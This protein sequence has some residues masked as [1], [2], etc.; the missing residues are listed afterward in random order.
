MLI[1]LLA[2]SEWRSPKLRVLFYPFINIMIASASTTYPEMKPKQMF[3]VLVYL[4]GDNGYSI[5]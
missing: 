5:P 4:T 3:I 1:D 2:D